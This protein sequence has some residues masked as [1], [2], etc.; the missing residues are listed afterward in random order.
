MICHSLYDFCTIFPENPKY[1]AFLMM[2]KGLLIRWS[3]VRSPSRSPLKTLYLLGF[4]LVFSYVIPIKNKRQNW[5]I[6]VNFGQDLY[7]FCTKCIN[8]GRK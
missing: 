8:R 5:S 1:K 7:D 6:L 3:W 2:I 4:S